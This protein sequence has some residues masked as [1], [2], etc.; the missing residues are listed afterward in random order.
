MRRQCN[1]GEAGELRSLSYHRRS[2]YQTFCFVFWGNSAERANVTAEGGSAHGHAAERAS[3]RAPV[4]ILL[5]FQVPSGLH[6]K[7]SK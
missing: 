1:K 4:F 3:R 2:R 7:M 6:I 5:Q